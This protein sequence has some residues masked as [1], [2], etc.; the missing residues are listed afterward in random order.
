MTRPGWYAA[1]MRRSEVM[2][3]LYLWAS[4]SILLHFGF[5]GGTTTLAGRIRPPA[6][7]VSASQALGPSEVEFEF[8]QPS[9]AP[10]PAPAPA[11]EPPSPQAPRPE[12]A[13][14]APRS[15]RALWWRPRGLCRCPCPPRRC[16]PRPRPNAR[17]RARSLST[18]R[19]PQKKPRP[20]DP[21][22]LAQSNR[23]VAEETVAAVRNLNRDDPA[24]QVGGPR[25]AT[26]RPEPGNADRQRSADSHNV[27]GD[28][29]EM[30]DESTRPPEPPRAP[31]SSRA[32]NAPR[33]TQATPAPPGS[34]ARPGDRQPGNDRAQGPRNG[35]QGTSGA[36]GETAGRPGTAG[37][38]APTAT[39]NADVAVAVG[40]GGQGGAG[41]DHGAGETATGRAG[42][43][44]NA[45]AGGAAGR[46]GGLEG[47]R[48]LGAS[49]ALDAMLPRY[50]TFAAVYGAEE[51]DR[52]RR[53]AEQRRSEARGSYADDWRQTREAIE[54]FTPSVRV[55]NQTALRTAASPFAAYLTAMHRRIHRFF[56]DTFLAGLEGAPGDSPLND[57]TLHTL[58][59]IVLERD[60]SVHRVGIVRTSGLLPFDVA[61]LNAVRRSG[62]Y[63]EAP[64]AI[65]SPD[66]RVYVRWGFYRNHRQCGTF[67]A[68]PFIL[69]GGGAPRRRPRARPRRPLRPSRRPPRR[70]WADERVDAGAP[71]E[72]DCGLRH[73]RSPRSG[74]ACA[75]RR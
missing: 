62:P 2:I 61:A 44:G 30:P 75:C 69:P 36:P 23:N 43:A 39:G 73:G 22:F 64:S 1:P 8:T 12:T 42:N 60:G 20:D 70:P 4:V 32:S 67:N 72:R 48:G 49:R 26:A 68:E 40:Q 6:P 24:P 51:L 28:R 7:P 27:Q 15:L 63:G 45:G 11:A 54:N 17:R 14:R 58:V 52:M 18:R 31:Q 10:T 55:G 71:P 5:F 53:V 38:A 59:E 41:G 16:P 57:P 50:D 47:I 19:T 56:A 21:H 66:Q 25:S 13:R 33:P 3:P 74:A 35:A 65:L 34:A 9:A 37:E 29:N 46:G